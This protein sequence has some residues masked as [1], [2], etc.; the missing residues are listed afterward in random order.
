MKPCEECREDV[1]FLLRALVEQEFPQ[2]AL[3]PTQGSAKGLPSND[4]FVLETL[5]EAA[6]I[7]KRHQRQHT[8]RKLISIATELDPD[9][10]LDDYWSNH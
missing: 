4:E 10:Q 8:R 3:S 6:E 2:E 9:A 5:T 7:F 1:S